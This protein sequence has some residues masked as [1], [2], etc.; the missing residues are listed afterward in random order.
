LVPSAELGFKVELGFKT[1]LGWKNQTWL[2]KPN[3]TRQTNLG[4]KTNLGYKPKVWF[5][6]QVR[7]LQ[8]AKKL[9]EK[10]DHIIIISKC[11]F[12]YRHLFWLRNMFLA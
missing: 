8:E 5:T 12:R 7:P 11:E 10:V 9:G 2:V 6:N 1:K 4:F 3:M